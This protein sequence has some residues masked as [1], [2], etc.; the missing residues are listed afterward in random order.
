MMDFVSKP[1]LCFS[2]AIYK[3]RNLRVRKARILPEWITKVTSKEARPVVS[4][5]F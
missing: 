5:P 1:E 4:K 3:A 2:T